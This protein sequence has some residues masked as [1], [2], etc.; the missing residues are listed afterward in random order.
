MIGRVRTCRLEP[1]PMRVVEHWIVQHRAIWE[2]RLDLLGDVL[3]DAFPDHEGT[4]Q[5][6]SIRQ[7]DFTIE[8][9]FR[10]SSEQRFKAFADPD[11]RQ[12]WFRVPDRWTDTEWSL[13]FRVGGGEL[14]AGRDRPSA[15]T[16]RDCCSTGSRPSS[17]TRC[18]REPH[19][20]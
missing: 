16:A 19:P 11:L 10:H 17:P 1:G 2:R 18:R 8:R 5:Q 20:V 4:S 14:N 12:C 6:M 13:D 9:R 3:D 7:H 15:S